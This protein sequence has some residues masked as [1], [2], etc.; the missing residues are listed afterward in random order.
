LYPG[1]GLGKS[2]V[3]SEDGDETIRLT[4]AFGINQMKKMK[5][6]SIWVSGILLAFALLPAAARGEGWQ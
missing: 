4:S 6:P 1:Y 3:P 2:G 5:R